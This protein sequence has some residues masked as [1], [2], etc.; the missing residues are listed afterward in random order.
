MIF[1]LLQKSTGFSAFGL[2]SSLLML[3][4]PVHLFISMKKF[5]GQGW[6][7]TIIKM[8][9]L[10]LFGLVIIMVLFIAF[11]LFSAFQL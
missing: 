10:N 8:I 11:I 5:Y 9:L 2:I 4:W 3:A 6:F 1:D 7:K